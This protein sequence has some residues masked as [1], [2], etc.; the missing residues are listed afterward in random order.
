MAL[1]AGSKLGPYEILSP[2]GAGGMG[3]VYRARDAKLGRDV[4]IKVL[5]AEYAQSRER[6]QRFE[7]EARAASALNHPNIIT[8][9]EV[10]QT[11]GTSYLAME[12]VEGRTLRQLL[13]AGPVPLKKALGIAAQVADGLAKAHTAGIV[14]RD[15]KPENVMLTSDGFAK[16]LDFGLVKLAG[17]AGS[18]SQ[19]P[20]MAAPATHPG[21]VM[22]TAGY[23][24][25]EQARGGEVDF[26]SDQFSLGTLLYEMVTGK[27]PFRRESSAQTLAAIIEDEPRPVTE[28]NPRTPAPVRWIIERCL[29]KEPE[30]RYAA[31]RDLARDLA[32][33]RDHLSQA[34]TSTGEMLLAPGAPVA[35]RRRLRLAVVATLA[36][37]AGVGLGALLFRKPPTEPPSLRTLTFSGADSQPSV[38]PDGRMVAFQ[39]IRDG[40]PKIWLKQ[41]AGGGEAPLTGGLD[42]NP[43]FSPDGSMLL[44]AH[45]EGAEVRIYRIAVFG[46]EARRL[47]EGADPEWSPDGKQIAFLRTRQEQG[48]VE[49]AVWVADADGSNA[50][51]VRSLGGVL[52][53]PR[54]SPDGRW[55]ALHTIVQGI[56]EESSQIALVKPDG[57]QLKWIQPVRGGA[58]STVLWNGSDE[59]VYAR[60][61]SVA[62]VGPAIPSNAT[63][64]VRQRI[65]GGTPEVILWYP[66]VVMSLDAMGRGQVVFDAVAA[67]QNLRESPLGAGSKETPRWLTHGSSIDRQPIYSPDGQWAVFSS[68]RAGNLDIWAVSTKDG[69][70]RRLTDDPGEDW[71]PAFTPDGKLIWSSNRS[72]NFEIWMAEADGS[73]AHQVSHDGVDAE[74]PTATADGWIIYN[75]G[76][77]KNRGLWKVRRDGSQARLLLA[78]QANWPELSP[79]GKYV[80]ATVTSPGQATVTVAQVSDGAVVAQIP[81]LNGTGRARFLPDGRRIAFSGTNAA[82]HTGLFVQDFVAHQDTRATRRELAGFDEEGALETFGFSR[83]GRRVVYGVNESYSLLIVAEGV[84]GVAKK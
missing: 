34:G 20:T 71:D 17:P 7:Q 5:A 41:I 48:T 66:G 39:S 57:S 72:G 62:A 47:A 74:N 82:G 55:I 79:D 58:L 69:S 6:L 40:V 11:D 61:Q 1:V 49:T 4:A 84:S 26:R 16:I 36:L 22:G 64:L 68:N 75:S 24:S 42:G 78:V 28:L 8:I 63:R 43:R 60:A 14:H 83:D 15:L 52:S 19:A 45:Q 50:R 23:M 30:E 10:G 13:D 51:L 3:E 38:S 80:L 12:Y 25:P 32:R 35:R 33:V 54:W 29:A 76:N 18:G 31:T 81:V 37:L 53:S 56:T 21:M 27:Q 2:L 70:V 73:S 44:F 46:G 9:Y 65:E 77:L 59:L 67:R